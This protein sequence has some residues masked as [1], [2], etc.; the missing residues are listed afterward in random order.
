MATARALLGQLY[1]NNRHDMTEIA[2]LWRKTTTN[3]QYINNQREFCLGH[4][5]LLMARPS[6][7]KARFSSSADKVGDILLQDVLECLAL[8][9]I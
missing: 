8:F 2:L 6:E 3:K 7:T 5:Y 9:F 1:I 4:C